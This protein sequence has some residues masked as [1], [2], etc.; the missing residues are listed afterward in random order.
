[1]RTGSVLARLALILLPTLGGSSVQAKGPSYAALIVTAVDFEFRAVSDLLTER[2][3]ETFGGRQWAIGRFGH[4]RFAVVRA[5]WGKAHAAAATSAGIERYSPSIVVMAGV[6]G[7]ISPRH[8]SSGDIVIAK[9]TF[10]HDL[11]QVRAGSLETWSP[12]TP[13]EKPYSG[14][15]FQGDERLAKQS[16]T[17]LQTLRLSPW[18]LKAGCQCEPDG[19]LISGCTVDEIEIGRQRPI[20]CIGNIATGDVFVVDPKAAA[21]V[22]W[23]TDAVAVDME[24]AAVAQEAA[25]RGLPFLAVRVIADTVGSPFGE[26]LYFCLKPLSG[27]RLSDVLRAILPVISDYVSV[28]QTAANGDAFDERDYCLVAKNPA[29]LEKPSLPDLQHELRVR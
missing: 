5:G 26:T 23:G 29:K 9:S 20:A 1:M 25:T 12:Q 27:R 8:V 16:L 17:A 22:S 15:F 3:E 7:G 19:T 6:G 18:K 4:E 2:T 28:T 11:G 14:E 10:Q 13:L 24:T 21:V